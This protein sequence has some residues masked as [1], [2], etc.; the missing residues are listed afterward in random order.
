MFDLTIAVFIRVPGGIFAGEGNAVGST[1]IRTYASSNTRAL[2]GAAVERSLRRRTPSP[3]RASA[4]NSRSPSQ[5]STRPFRASLNFAK[6]FGSRRRSKTPPLLTVSEKSTSTAR[7]SSIAMATRSSPSAATCSIRGNSSFIG[8]DGARDRPPTSGPWRHPVPSPEPPF[9]YVE[10]PATRLQPGQPTPN[11]AR[12]R[13]RFSP[14]TRAFQA[15]SALF[16]KRSSWHRVP[17]S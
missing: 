2:K 8:V 15:D 7:P 11:S 17:N 10:M 9:T 13:A 16:P 6:N 14:S 5:A 3:W 4:Q 12:R 1:A